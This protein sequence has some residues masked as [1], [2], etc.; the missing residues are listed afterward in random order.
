MQGRARAG[1]F[2]T[3]RGPVVTPLF[4]PVGTQGSVKAVDHRFLKEV[5]TQT[6]LCN[7]YHLY[8][9]PGR[10]IARAAGGLHS[11]IGWDRPILTDSGG[12]QVFSLSDLRGI[13][14]DGVR[15]KSHLDG[16]IHLF[17]PESVVDLQ[18]DLGSD[19]MMV[20]DECVSYPCEE[21]YALASNRLTLRWAAR[22]R[23]QFLRTRELY[24]HTQSLFAIV[25][26]ST[27]AH[28]REE[29]ARALVEMDFPGYAIGGLSVG[30]PSS[31]MYRMVEVCTGI[32]PRDKPRY[33]MGVGTPENLLEAIARGV[34]MF[35]CVLPTR[36][37]RNATLFTTSGKLHIRNAAYATDFRPVDGECQCY[38]C[39]NFT[40]AYL[41]HLFKAQEILALQ[42]AS[43]HNLS[44]Y[45]WLCRSAREAITESRFDLWMEAQMKR[46][47]VDVAT[48][49]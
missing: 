34:D 2:E 22:C 30:E 37:G 6:L 17:T 38:T 46:L 49:Q 28:V 42:L 27:Y 3:S 29:S 33:L 7:A 41:R 25:Q 15:F 13:S 36:N 45:H 47:S 12:F 31:E 16:S 11:F 24:G 48:V 1:Q 40:R 8:L 32:L 18:R 35:D 39:K 14:D 23:E 26:G 19:I 10:E 9:R 4:M 43:V 44:F 5:G 20:L 21:Q